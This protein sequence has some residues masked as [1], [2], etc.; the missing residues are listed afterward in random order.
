MPE[1]T[2]VLSSWG[3]VGMRRMMKLFV[4]VL[5]QSIMWGLWKERNR[6]IFEGVKKDVWV[7]RDSILCKVGLWM[8]TVNE[9]SHTSLNDMMRDWC[10][11]LD[12]LVL[13]DWVPPPDGV[14]KLNF[15]GS[16]LGNPGEAGYGCIVQDENEKVI[17]VCC[18]LVGICDSTKAECLGL[19]VGRRELKALGFQSVYGEGGL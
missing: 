3:G 15:D 9:F 7:V 2:K 11:S 14:F 17:M 4:R 13:S 8:L 6:G 10:V 1:D 5:A 16:S 12:A 19:L 18:G